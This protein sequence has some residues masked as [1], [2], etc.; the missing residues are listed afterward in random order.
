MRPAFPPGIRKTARPKMSNYRGRTWDSCYV[1][2]IDGAETEGWLD[3]TWGERFYFTH[4]NQWWFGPI[5][6]FQDMGRS[7]CGVPHFDLRRA[8]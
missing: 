2:L 8:A 5:A 3:T 6:G 1:V 7:A 4:E